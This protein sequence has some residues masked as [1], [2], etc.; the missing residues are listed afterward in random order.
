[1]LSVQKW[2]PFFRGSTKEQKPSEKTF[3]EWCFHLSLQ[4]K[5]TRSYPSAFCTGNSGREMLSRSSKLQG[6]WGLQVCKARRMQAAV[7]DKFSQ[8][9][10]KSDL[11]KERCCSS[12]SEGTLQ[13]PREDF[14]SGFG[15]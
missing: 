7:L 3:P 10:L 12:S 8:H 5:Q 11:R 2:H 6:I 15:F 13:Q 9:F 14:Q 1:M 4:K